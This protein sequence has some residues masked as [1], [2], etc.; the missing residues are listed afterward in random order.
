[1]SEGNE[2]GT[3]R[4]KKLRHDLVLLQVGSTY[5]KKRKDRDGF[6]LTDRSEDPFNLYY[7]DILPSLGRGTT[8]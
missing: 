4:V 5:T 1:M 3:M 6:I 8:A 2:G 7:A